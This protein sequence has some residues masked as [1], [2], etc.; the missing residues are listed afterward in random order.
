[1]GFP[2]SL[3]G[4]LRAIA[5]AALPTLAAGLL[6]SC[7]SDGPNQTGGQYLAEHG[8]ILQN[9]MYHVQVKGFPVAG[10]WT[11]DAEPGHVNDTVLLAGIKGPFSAEPRFSF[12]IQ[13]TSLLT[14]LSHAD[15]SLRLSV[16]TPTWQNVGVW[17][18]NGTSALAGLYD[19]NSVDSIRFRVLA[20]DLS[21]SG[22]TSS[23]T[24]NDSTARWN[25]RFL[26]LGDTLA[27]LPLPDARDTIW[28]KVKHALKETSQ[29]QARELPILKALLAGRRGHKHAVHVRMI[30]D[31]LGVPDSLSAMLRLGGQWAY[32]G[33]K[34]PSLLFGPDLRADTIPAKYRLGPLTLADGRSAVAYTLRYAGP[35]GTMV[36]PIR[37]GLHVTL[38]RVRLLDSIEAG[39]IRLKKVPPP[40]P[41]GSLSLAYYVP[42]A[43]ISLPIVP[44]KLEADLPVQVTLRTGIDTLLGAGT[45]GLTREDRVGVDSSISPWYTTEV[46]H[47][48]TIVNQVSLSYKA[49]GDSLRR[50]IL[51][52]SKDSL[53]N[54]TLFLPV[55]GKTQI[56]LSLSGYGKSNLLN[57]EVQAEADHLIA[58]SY[59]S[60]RSADEANAFRDPATG[61][62]VTDLESLL[63]HFVHP[64]DKAIRL[65]ATAGIQTLLNQADLGTTTRHDFEFRPYNRAYNDSAITPAGATVAHEVSFPVL[66]TLQPR[67]ESGV[68]SVD[69]DVY[70]YPLKAR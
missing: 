66:S 69:L 11:T 34:R 55:G 70:L 25:R 4:S 42:F 60:L 27:D 41:T 37:R 26:L 33:A 58:R 8:V 62:N 51:G 17:K 32:D 21:D 43:A 9:P 28:L 40:R 61:E 35:A 68:L 29:L 45:G 14:T 22:F 65:R 50:V 30:P 53:G 46:G 15:S 12:F 20:W 47:P 5:K 3:P 16:S 44:A 18:D 2:T 63:P 49:F 64:N 36:V 1:M 7:I 24:W 10:F 23:D 54:D 56:N 31:T 48:E 52:F 57:I 6:A 67:I 19:S 13:D 59:L 38:D 39:L